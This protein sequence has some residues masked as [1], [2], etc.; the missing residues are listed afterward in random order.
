MVSPIL[1]SLSRLGR[2]S[3]HA[4]GV[5]LMF[6]NDDINISCL[7]TLLRHNH[8]PHYT[9]HSSFPCCKHSPCGPALLDPEPS[10][11]RMLSPVVITQCIIILQHSNKTDLKA[12]Q[13]VLTCL[14][15]GLMNTTLFPLT[16]SPLENNG[17]YCSSTIE[18]LQQDMQYSLHLQVNDV[19]ISYNYT[20]CEFSS[21]YALLESLM[22]ENVLMCPHYKVVHCVLN[23][24]LVH[25][26]VLTTGLSHARRQMFIVLHEVGN[27]VGGL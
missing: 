24:M 18:A 12:V 6:W 11:H 23:S 2:Y 26:G 4:Y 17:N 19:V 3:Q 9:L 21:A 27:K 16:L 10:E 25:A 14:E 20:L 5:V 22:V 7:I 15:N 13:A 1:V 8:D